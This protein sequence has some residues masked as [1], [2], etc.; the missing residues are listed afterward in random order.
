MVR[1]GRE[2]Q[3]PGP[4]AYVLMHAGMARPI[5]GECQEAARGLVRALIEWRHLRNYR[6]TTNSGDSHGGFL[7]SAGRCDIGVWALD[8]NYSSFGK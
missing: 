7:I 8:H 2:T 5:A 3:S 1:A 6:L 4:S